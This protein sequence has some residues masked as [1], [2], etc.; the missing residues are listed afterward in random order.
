M[1]LHQHANKQSTSGQAK[2]GA[3]VMCS[4]LYMHGQ[5]Q[6][7]EGE[8]ERG[9]H[10]LVVTQW[11]AG[12]SRRPADSTARGRQGGADCRN[13]G[14]QA[15]WWLVGAEGGHAPL[16]SNGDAPP[17]GKQS[18]A[19]GCAAPPAGSRVRDCAAWEGKGMFLLSI[20]LLYLFPIS[21]YLDS[22]PRGRRTAGSNTREPF[23]RAGS[24][25]FPRG[26]DWRQ[27]ASVPRFPRVKRPPQPPG[28]RSDAYLVKADAIRMLR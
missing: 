17:E 18:S 21:C 12:R 4:V 23:F 24:R 3:H 11:K 19:Q 2:Q 14:R 16:Q 22:F 27:A 8:S 6:I 15:P 7:E 28:R 26:K 5:G 10:T 25:F 9:R 13:R 1:V 20:P